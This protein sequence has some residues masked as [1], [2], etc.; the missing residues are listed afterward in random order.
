M[1]EIQAYK[2]MQPAKVKTGKLCLD[3]LSGVEISVEVH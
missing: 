1:H 2:S 3:R